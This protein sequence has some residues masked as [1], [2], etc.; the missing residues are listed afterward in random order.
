LA[1]ICSR[2]GDGTNLPGLRLSLSK[3]RIVSA[4]ESRSCG[5]TP[6]IPADRAPRLPRTRSHATVRKTRLN[7]SSNRH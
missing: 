7:R 6:S 3:G 1:I 5:V 4:I 2:A